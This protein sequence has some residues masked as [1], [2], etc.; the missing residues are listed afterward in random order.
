MTVTPFATS[1]F[2]LFIEASQASFFNV[3]RYEI[4]LYI[5]KKFKKDSFKWTGGSGQGIVIGSRFK[6]S[7]LR[8]LTLLGLGI[9]SELALLSLCAM[10]KVQ[11]SKFNGEFC[12]LYEKWTVTSGQWIVGSD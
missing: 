7:S 12:E 6:V 11:S 3:Q 9:A 8:S 1:R 4:I 10:V 5:E 2:S